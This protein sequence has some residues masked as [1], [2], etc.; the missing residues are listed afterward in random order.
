MSFEEYDAFV[1]EALP[2][3]IPVPSSLDPRE[4]MGDAIYYKSNGRMRQRPGVHGPDNQCQDLSGEKVLLSREFQYF[5]DASIKL[6]LSLQSLVRQGR[7]HRSTAN[8][9]YADEFVRWFRALRY[10]LNGVH[11]SPQV[12]IEKDAVGGVCSELRLRCAD[13]DESGTSS[14]ARLSNSGLHLSGAGK[15][16]AEG[17]RLAYGPLWMPTVLRSGPYRFFFYAG[18]GIEP[19]HVHVERDEK[20]AKFWLR[21][22]RLQDSG[23]FSRVEL[24]RLQAIVHE[25]L[26][27]LLRSWNAFFEQ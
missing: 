26:E 8:D 4:R 24:T 22:V 18:D 19:P 11:G 16:L 23:G 17:G 1:R 15:D 5:G 27:M 7:G 25:N 3:K 12:L 6:P 2:Q 21:P 14:S 20:T 10:E 9:P 13:H